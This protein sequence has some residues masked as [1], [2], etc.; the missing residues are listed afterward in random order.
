MPV[1]FVSVYRVKNVKENYF[2]EKKNILRGKSRN[3][4]LLGRADE[5]MPVQAYMR[6]AIHP[7]G[8]IACQACLIKFSSGVRLPDRQVF[9]AIHYEA[10]MI[11]YGSL[12]NTGLGLTHQA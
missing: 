11:V 5:L 1:R 4:L 8:L 2:S 6:T 12:N 10:C 9:P 3:I 7:L